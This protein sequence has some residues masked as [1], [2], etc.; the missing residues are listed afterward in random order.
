MKVEILFPE[1]CNLYGDLQNVYYLQRSCD[2]LEIVETK[3]KNKPSF[4]NDDTALVYIGSTTEKGLS[5]AYESLLPYKD[6]ICKK[7]DEGQLMLATGNALDIFGNYIQ[8]DEETKINGLGI[9]NTYAKYNMLL[10]HNSFFVGDF[11]DD[12]NEKIKIVGF[13]SLFGHTYPTDKNIN[14]LFITT[15]GTGQNPF[16]K[17]EGFRK[18]NFLLTHLI[19]PIII[20]NP[21]FAKYLLRSMNAK[22]DTLAFEEAA[23][24]S[25]SVRL[26]E[27]NEPNRS[28]FYE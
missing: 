9:I 12:R 28:P 22:N 17:N 6:D 21:L 24:K 2:D 19:G 13:K 1:V 26:K 11:N 20:L 8:I 23:F 5:L 7:I 25:Y 10:R 27:F 15:K 16:L 18:K 4:L 14:P 3:L